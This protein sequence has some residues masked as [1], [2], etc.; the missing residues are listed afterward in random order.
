MITVL[1]VFVFNKTYQKRNQETHTFSFTHSFGL[2]FQ[3]LKLTSSFETMSRSHVP[4]TLSFQ[5]KVL[6]PE[7]KLI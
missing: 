7:A 6:K 3:N 4:Y 2:W 5:L 1:I